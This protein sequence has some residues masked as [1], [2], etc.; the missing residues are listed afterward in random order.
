MSGE[1]SGEVFSVHVDF[2]NFL[3]RLEVEVFGC[4]SYDIAPDPYLWENLLYVFRWIMVLLGHL[5]VY[6][7]FLRACTFCN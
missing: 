5:S 6:L 2:M 1:K 7:T 4:L 3:E